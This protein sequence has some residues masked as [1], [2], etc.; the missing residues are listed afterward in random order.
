MF[1]LPVVVDVVGVRCCSLLI[2]VD[3]CLCGGG[4]VQNGTKYDGEFYCCSV[5]PIL[6]PILLL[7]AKYM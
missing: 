4:H 7:H 5:F 2:V 6:V 1:L 3:R